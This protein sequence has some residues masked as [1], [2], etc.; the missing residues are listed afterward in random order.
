MPVGTRGADGHT[1]RASRAGRAGPARGRAGRAV[2]APRAG[3]PHGGRA[4]HGHRLPDRAV[5]CR[6]S[7]RAVRCRRVRPGRAVRPGPRRPRG[8]AGTAQAT[9]CGRVRAGRAVWPGRAGRRPVANAAGVSD[10]RDTPR[11]DRA[12]AWACRPRRAV[13]RERPPMAPPWMSCRVAVIPERTN[14]TLDRLATQPAPPRAGPGGA[15]ATT[16][17]HMPRSPANAQP[18][19]QQGTRASRLRTQAGPV[20]VTASGTA[21]PRATEGRPA[22]PGAH[23]DPTRGPPCTHARAGRRRAGQSGE[24]HAP[25]GPI[26]R[27]GRRGARP[28]TVPVRDPS[29]ARRRLRDRR[30][31]HRQADVL[32]SPTHRQTRHAARHRTCPGSLGSPPP[33][34]RPTPDP[35]TGRRTGRAD[36][37]NGPTPTCRPLVCGPTPRAVGPA[38]PQ[39]PRAVRPPR[40]RPRVAGPARCRPRAP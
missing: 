9:R 6:G 40:R 25:G 4:G 26:P 13:Q 12:H 19:A 27:R 16:S 11:P 36:V 7:A 34:P 5:R 37:R 1:R 31:I 39:A 35:P 32:G 29:A 28:V 14:R 33:T 15:S 21:P 22:K 3:P 8:T 10:G 20:R 23:T 30:P 17:H 24:A 18:G 38:A 2:A